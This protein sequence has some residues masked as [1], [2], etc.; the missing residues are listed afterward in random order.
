MR[1]SNSSD[2]LSGATF[3]DLGCTVAGTQMRCAADY[4]DDDASF[5]MAGPLADTRYTGKLSATIQGT[6]V[7]GTLALERTAQP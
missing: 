1:P 4:P 2:R 6:S 5:S 7:A 3:L